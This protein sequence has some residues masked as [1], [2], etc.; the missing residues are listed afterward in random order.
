MEVSKAELLRCVR[1][2]EE[3]KERGEIYSLEELEKHAE[4]W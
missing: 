2:S 1:L 3:Q 4:T